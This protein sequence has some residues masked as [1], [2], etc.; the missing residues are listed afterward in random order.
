MESVGWF[1]GWVLSGLVISAVVIANRNRGECPPGWF[2]YVGSL[3]IVGI[4]IWV[5]L[6][7]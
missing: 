2:A 6:G 3:M 1:I 5:G 4:T 7:A